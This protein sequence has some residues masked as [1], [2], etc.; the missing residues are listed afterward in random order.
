M[1]EL[2]NSFCSFSRYI[3]KIVVFFFLLWDV[4]IFYAD[5]HTIFIIF[6]RCFFCCCYC[7]ERYF[8]QSS[9]NDSFLFG[10]RD[11][12]RKR[13]LFFWHKEQNEI[14][15]ISMKNEWLSYVHIYYHGELWSS[16]SGHKENVRTSFGCCFFRVL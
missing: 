11:R 7:S 9:Q 3:W 13:K 2:H 16:R 8:L 6:Y 12:E 5:H 1:P 15:R 14:R 4:S 10:K